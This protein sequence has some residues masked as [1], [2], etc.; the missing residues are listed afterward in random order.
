MMRL[1][2]HLSFLCAL[3]A[4]SSAAMGNEVVVDFDEITQGIY[5]ENLTSNEFRLSPSS[6][7]DIFAPGGASNDKVMGWDASGPSNP[8]YLG[9]RRQDWSSVYVD[10]FERPFTF[11]SVLFEQTPNPPG[12]SS[13][14]YAT[15]TSSKGGLFD[16]TSLPD[17]TFA[18]LSGPQWNGIKWLE[19]SYFGNAGAPV[20]LLDD[21]TFRVAGFVAPVPEPE[22]YAMVLLGLGVVG[23]AARRRSRDRI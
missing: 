19:F 5:S 17:D 11:A 1:F 13:T 3:S 22:T 4:V 21:L 2:R 23:L 18:S 16:F 12:S 7:V 9:Q 6:H 10:Y 15:I 20:F 8:D 14:G